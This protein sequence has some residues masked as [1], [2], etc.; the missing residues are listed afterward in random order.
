M[1]LT[2][3][4]VYFLL[5]FSLLILCSRNRNM[6]NKTD[7]SQ[8]EIVCSVSLHILAVLQLTI[9]PLMSLAM[10]RKDFSSSFKTFLASRQ[11]KRR[12][13]T[14]SIQIGFLF[15][16]ITEVTSVLNFYCEGLQTYQGKK[17]NSILWSP[18][19]NSITHLEFG[20]FYFSVFS[21][22]YFSLRCCANSAI[23]HW[24]KKV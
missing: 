17:V 24:L 19:L 14:K 15:P 10:P 5:N 7:N 18:N 21:P 20:W 16:Q 6:S 3:I 13:S 23:C 22:F 8:T 9:L 12:S 11:T 2:W 1:G 4:S